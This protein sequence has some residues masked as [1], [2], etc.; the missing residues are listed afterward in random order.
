M[1]SSARCGSPLGGSTL[2]TSAPRSASTAPAAGTK[3]QLATSTTRTPCNGPA[4]MSMPP[5]CSLPSRDGYTLFPVGGSGQ[6]G[7]PGNFVQAP[8]ERVVAQIGRDGDHV[9]GGVQ[10][11]RAVVDEDDGPVPGW[12]SGRWVV[13]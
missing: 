1:L 3:V 13:R 2:M 4:M 10:V 5:I 7:S 9:E 6:P 11:F 12:E 8:V